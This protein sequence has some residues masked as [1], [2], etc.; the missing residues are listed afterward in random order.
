MTGGRVFSYTL[1]MTIPSDAILAEL[2]RLREG[3]L[4]RG[5]ETLPAVGG[6]FE[7]GGRRCLN[8]SSNDYLN[9]ATHPRLR[10]AA[11][12]AIDEY[13]CGA[14]ASRLMSGSLGVH[15]DLE[16]RL[17]RLVGME[18]A[19]VFPTGYQ[20]NVGVVTA[21][22]GRDA[23]VFSDALNHA[24]IIDG[25]RLSKCRT[26][27]YPHNDVGALEKLLEEKGCGAERR[28]II[29]DSLFSMDGDIADLRGLATL[30]TGYDAILVVDEA[31]ALGVFG[32]GRGLCAELG[33]KADVLVGTLG[34]A[35]GSAGGFAASTV[36]VRDLLVNR[37]RSFIYS[38]GLAPGC[39]ASALMGVELVEMAGVMGR[40][41]LGR[42]AYFGERL[43]G[44]GL[45]VG[46]VESQIIPI[47]I[48]GNGA[49]IALAGALREAGIFV[50]GIRPPTVAEGTARLRLSVTLAHE[51]G[52]L[53]LAAR[54]IGE[55]VNRDK[56]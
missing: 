37:A 12:L 50:T 14:T 38:T 1:G 18:T 27:V 3:D 54:V 5:L 4:L 31:H 13:G 22:A 49:T 16:V 2:D 39:A 9:L 15:A 26:V 44:A 41:L 51:Q 8:F 56:N 33:V 17:A 55:F 34:K 7:M 43:R 24:S 47:M 11:K 42:A 52:D 53:D 6:V 21:L 40:E 25:I 28:L 29:S 48:G 32:E 46:A 45:A 30:A 35:L 23:V 36:G 19:L 10:E 20:T